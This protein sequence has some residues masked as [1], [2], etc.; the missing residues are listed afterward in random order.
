MFSERNLWNLKRCRHVC[1]YGLYYRLVMPNVTYSLYD[2]CRSLPPKLQSGCHLCWGRKSPPTCSRNWRAETF[3]FVSLFTRKVLCELFAK[4]CPEIKLGRY[5][6][7]ASELLLY[8][9]SC[10]AGS[11]E[12]R[13]CPS[14]CKRHSSSRCSQIRRDQLLLL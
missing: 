2:S 11:V 14:V 13:Q 10:R 5:H 12:E 8:K 6:K 3:A 7:G 1:R 9:L 4:L